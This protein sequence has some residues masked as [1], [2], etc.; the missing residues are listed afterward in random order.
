MKRFLSLWLVCCLLVLAAPCALAEVEDYTVAGKLFKQLWAGSGFTGTL[1]VEAAAQKEGAAATQKPLVFDV[2]YIYVRPDETTTGEHRADIALV[3]GEETLSTLH[4]QLK[5]DTA[6]FQADVAGDRWYAFTPGGE[7]EAAQTVSAAGSEALAHTGM[8]A[9]TEL[10][11]SAAAALSGADSLNGSLDDYTTRV[12][13]WIEGH[14]QDAVLGKLDDG[15]T[16]MEV[17]Y[18]VSPAAIKAQVKQLVFD[19]L[20]DTETLASLQTALG[21]EM[22]SLYL[23]PAL[24]SWYFDSIEALPLAGDMTISRTVSVKGD[25]LSLSLELPLYDQQGGNVLLRYERTQGEGDLPDNNVI[26][27]ESAL[28][29]MDISYQEYSSMTG[30]NVVRGTFESEPADGSQPIAAAFTLRQEKGESKDA[31]K[32]DVYSY[33]LKLSLSPVEE[34]AFPETEI[35][36]DSSFASKELKSAATNVQATLTLGGDG[37]DSAVTLT[38][39]GASCKK[40]EPQPIAGEPVSLSAMSQ[41]E[42]ALLLPGPALQLTTLLKPYLTQ[43]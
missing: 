7:G 1:T 23:N 15:T 29:T 17:N 34:G 11:L 2:D 30:V 37:W 25:T 35:S 12:D 32:R 3:D 6:A 13:V 33:A 42:L 21:E 14:R 8:P 16:T 10:M 41:A 18:R 38:F 28:R 5:D 43:P 36:L 22:A 26:H 20:N 19:L 4:V 9:L 24:L 39:H 31:E 40:W 27:L